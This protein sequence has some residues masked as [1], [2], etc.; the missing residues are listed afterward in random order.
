MKKETVILYVII[1]L[2][3]GFVGGA[4]VGILWVTKSTEKTAAVQ[5]PQTAPPGVP[6]MAPPARD[7]MELASQIQ[8]LKEIIKKDPKNLPAWVEL[9]N[10]YFDSDRPQE[11]IEAYRQYL[12][13]KPDNPDVRTDMGIMYRKLGQFDKALEAFRKSAQSDSKHVNSRYNIGIVL[14]HDKQDINGAIKAW[15]EYLRLDPN[16][17]RAQ[18]IKSQIEKMKAMQPPTK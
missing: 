9:G 3:V 5:K 13:V 10:L 18:R 12:A 2:V 16:S 4:T 17:E 8:T 7:P 14:L 11:A 6:A 1:A 15:E